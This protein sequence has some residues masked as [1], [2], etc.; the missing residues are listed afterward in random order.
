MWV[1]TSVVYDKHT[2]TLEIRGQKEPKEMFG[3]KGGGKG[4][5]EGGPSLLPNFLLYLSE[6]EAESHLRLSPLPLPLL[7]FYAPCLLF[8]HR[9]RGR[10][11]GVGKSLSSPSLCFDPKG[12]PTERRRKTEKRAIFEIMF[13]E[14][15]EYIRFACSFFLLI[16]SDFSI[17]YVQRKIVFC[18]VGG[19]SRLCWL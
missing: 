3:R 18:V 7:P 12:V 10:R 19:T 5:E 13:L 9:L 17:D 14:V 11:R 2:H 6:V 1:A 16:L 8:P 15:L 4:C